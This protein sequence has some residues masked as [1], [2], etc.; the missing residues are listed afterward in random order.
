[1]L[2]DKYREIFEGQDWKYY[3]GLYFANC[4]FDD[5]SIAET[6]IRDYFKTGGKENIL[7]KNIPQDKFRDIHSI[8][9]FF[10]GLHLKEICRVPD[11]KPDFRYMWFITCLYHDYGYYFENSKSKFS[12]KNNNLITL[13]K[14]IKIEYRLLESDSYDTKW[15]ETILRYYDFCRQEKC[16]I[17]HGIVG[18]IMLYDKLLKNFYD[19]REKAKEEAR[20]KGL[21]IDDNDFEYNNLHWSINHKEFYKL[22]S[23]SIILHNIWYAYTEKDKELYKSKGLDKLI[24]NN[25]D[26]KRS[27]SSNAFFFLLLLAD[28]IEPIKAF[29]NISHKCLLTKIDIETIGDNKIIITVSDNCLNYQGWFDKIKDLKNWLKLS[30]PQQTETNKLV[31]EIK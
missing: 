4:P 10:L 12:P 5:D 21:N 31:I 25:K 1:M 14:K 28:T 13:L 24:I 20:E 18:G 26:D 8:S 2:L 22:A 9:T 7:D 16:F 19:N 6:F 27:C 11:L 3:S 23:D 17:N 15:K 30:I 29:P